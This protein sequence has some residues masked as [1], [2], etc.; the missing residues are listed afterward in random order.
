[1]T[2]SQQLN[3]ADCLE[4]VRSCIR[5]SLAVVQEPSIETQE[6]L[7]RRLER[8]ATERL[9][10]KRMKSRVKQDRQSHNIQLWIIFYFNVEML[11]Y[12][13]LIV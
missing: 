9:I 2:R 8:A 10:V 7:R 11:W 4:K 12:F 6:K 1:M 3:L 13:S 5:N